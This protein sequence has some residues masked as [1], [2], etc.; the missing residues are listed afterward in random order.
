[1]EI[2]SKNRLA[3]KAAWERASGNTNIPKCQKCG[4]PFD[5]WLPTLHHSKEFCS[6]GL[7]ETCFFRYGRWTCI[8]WPTVIGSVNAAAN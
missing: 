4:T 2:I 7:C 6:D 5:G 8:A 3:I 1:M